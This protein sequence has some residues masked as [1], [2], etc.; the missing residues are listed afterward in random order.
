MAFTIESVT[1][2]VA[3]SSPLYG[4][5]VPLTRRRWELTPYGVQVNKVTWSFSFFNLEC[6]LQCFMIVFVYHRK[7]L[8]YLEAGLHPVHGCKIYRQL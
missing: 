3:S 2:S 6:F 1:D 5:L 4:T 8:I 7:N